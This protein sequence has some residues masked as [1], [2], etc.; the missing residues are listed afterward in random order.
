M[1]R[2]IELIVTT[3]IFCCLI[4]FV[5]ITLADLDF[6][7]L[8]IMP[9]VGGLSVGI[10]IATFKKINRRPTFRELLSRTYIEAVLQMV[11]GL[12]FLVAGYFLMKA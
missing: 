10:S 8:W 11:I 12:A 5:L 3:L 2:K 7:P 4:V 9:I 6:T 1:L